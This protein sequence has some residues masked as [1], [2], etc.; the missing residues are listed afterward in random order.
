[1][2]VKYLDP[3]KDDKYG[4]IRGDK[5]EA[6][7][8]FTIDEAKVYKTDD[9]YI[10]AGL[11]SDYKGVVRSYKPELPL[12]PGLCAIPIYGSEYEIRRKDKDGT[13]VSDKV[14]PSVFEKALYNYI[15][16]HEADWLKDDENLAGD[17]TFVPNMLTE[18]MSQEQLE[19]QIHTNCNLEG[20]VPFGDLPPYT[21]P[22][23]YGQRKSYGGAKGVSPDEKLEFV[24]KELIA[25]TDPRLR[26]SDSHLGDIV[27]AF[28]EAHKGNPELVQD[29]KAIILACIS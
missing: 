28:N 9:S 29:C 13:W 2:N 20:I 6:F 23:N 14:Q 19:E 16:E 24:K 21:P 15:K 3:Y 26:V 8:R 1:M 4:K 17:I 22:A 18:N 25:L 7:L 27:R 10:L 11:I 5:A 12:E